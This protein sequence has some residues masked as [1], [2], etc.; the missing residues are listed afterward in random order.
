MQ[1]SP[2]RMPARKGASEVNIDTVISGIIA[3]EGT[4][5]TNNP[6]DKG[7]PTKYG[8]TQAVARANGY[9]GDMQNLDETTA[10][11]IYKN[12]YWLQPK[13]D[14]LALIDEA[15]AEKVLDIKVN[16]GN[17]VTFIQRYLNTMNYMGVPFA[18]LVADGGLG[19]ATF[20]AIKAYYKQRGALGQSTLYKSVQA[21]QSVRYMTLAEADKTQEQFSYGWQTQRAFGV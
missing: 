7:G 21:Q 3:R 18:D 5:Y 8:I 15:L 14:Q 10:R 1:E 9:Q 6:N 20:G 12:V 4:A 17:G 2:A 19:P 11:N 16:G 13:F